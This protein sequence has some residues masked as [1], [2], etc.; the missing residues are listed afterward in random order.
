M[1]ICCNILFI[2]LFIYFILF[3]VFLA[4]GALFGGAYIASVA[5]G[6]SQL[7]QMG[8]LTSSILCILALAGLSSVETARLG[9]VAGILGVGTGWIATCGFMSSC[10]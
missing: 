9:N 7:T 6:Y 1:I 2:Y 10:K 4:P 5:M 3:R 8:Y